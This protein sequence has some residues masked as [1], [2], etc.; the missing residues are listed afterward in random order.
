MMKASRRTHLIFYLQ[1]SLQ[2]MICTHKY[3]SI[4][5]EFKIV[6]EE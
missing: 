3:F 5:I 4:Q 2:T 1:N 6:H